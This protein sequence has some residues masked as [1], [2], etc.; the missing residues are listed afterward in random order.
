MYLIIIK[1][2]I[3]V[4]DLTNGLFMLLLTILFHLN[5]PKPIRAAPSAVKIAWAMASIHQLINTNTQPIQ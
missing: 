1:S 2:M 4:P 5:R 3:H